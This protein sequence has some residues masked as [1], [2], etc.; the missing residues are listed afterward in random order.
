MPLLL[1]LA[2]PILYWQ[3]IPRTSAGPSDL[4]NTVKLPSPGITFHMNEASASRVPWVNSNGWRFMR[5]PDAHF[6]YDV[7]GSTATLAA[8]EAFCFHGDAVIQTDT[9]GRAPLEKMLAFLRSLPSAEGPPLADIGFIDDGSATAAEVMNLLVREN[10]MFKIVRAPES[11]LKLTVRLGSKEYPLEEAKNPDRMEHTIRAN[12]TDARRLI[13]IY[14]T[15]I[16]VARVTGT[17][18]KLRIHLLNYGAGQ[19][20]RVGAFRV[21]ILGHYSKAQLH[22]FDSPD[23]QVTDYTP[24]QD[25]TDFTIPELKAYAVVDLNR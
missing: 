3:N 12:L 15:S 2:L 18:G 8:A 16:V 22:S 21:R 11:D 13:R 14:G 25:A 23:D 10:L 1:A 17:S 4:A 24:E 5:Q 6:S 20:A 9:S 7:K 19:G